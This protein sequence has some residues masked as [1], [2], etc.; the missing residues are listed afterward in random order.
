M[1]VDESGSKSSDDFNTM[2]SFVAEIVSGFDL[3]PDKVQI[4]LTLFS[5]I[6][7]TKCH[8]NTHRTNESLL[9]A[10]HH[11]QQRGGGET[12]SALKHVLHNNFRPDVGM[13]ADSRKVLLLITDGETQDETCAPSQHLNDTGIQVY[14]IDP[15]VHIIR[16][17]LMLLALLSFI[18]AVSF[19]H[20][21]TRGQR[22]GPE[23]NIEPEEGAQAA[24][25]FLHPE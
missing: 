12:G 18:P 8:L 7:E 16:L 21:T 3:G 1:L 13:R 4:G 22:P 5:S 14:T 23:E 10:V 24:E 20:K 15:S 19:V 9:K 6:V 17:V 11:L 25:Y 2:K